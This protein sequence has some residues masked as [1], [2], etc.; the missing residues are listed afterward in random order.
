MTLTRSASIRIRA[1]VCHLRQEELLTFVVP[2][3][4]QFR[5]ETSVF[6]LFSEVVNKA[7]RGARV[8]WE[9]R[10]VRGFIA[11]VAYERFRFIG[12][13]ARCRGMPADLVRKTFANRESERKNSEKN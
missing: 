8:A 4:Q 5:C 1:T 10:A 2:V 6:F 7:T 13:A 11:S 3:R 12:Q 9:Q